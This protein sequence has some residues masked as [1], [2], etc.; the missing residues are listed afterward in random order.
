MKIEAFIKLIE[1]NV[2]GIAPGSLQS[3]TVLTSIPQWDSLAV[4]TM[5]AQFDAEYG[6]QVS[7]TEMQRCSTVSDLFSTVSSK[8]TKPS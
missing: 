6:V 4:L 8:V 1:D 7:G 2:D 5:L 3:D